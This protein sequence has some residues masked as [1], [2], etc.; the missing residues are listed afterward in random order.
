[1]SRDVGNTSS[2]NNEEV[3]FTSFFGGA[4]RGR[5]LQLTQSRPHSQLPVVTHQSVSMTEQQVRE[6]IQI[7][8]AWLED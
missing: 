4:D 8:Q 5:S 1:M 3:S 6:A 2:Q 7:M